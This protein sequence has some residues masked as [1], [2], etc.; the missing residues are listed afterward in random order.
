MV[1]IIAFIDPLHTI[2]D[3]HKQPAVRPRRRRRKGFFIFLLV[4]IALAGAVAYPP[5]FLFLVRQALTAEAWRY[6]FQL[7]IGQMEGSVRGPLWLYN[8]QL[9]HTSEAGTSTVLV[10]NKARTSFAWKH[11]IWQKDV[12][13]W[14]DLALDG[15]NGD[16]DLP[17]DSRQGKP[18]TTLFDLL[19]SHKPP[20]LPLPTFLRISHANIAIRQQGGMV[21]LADLNLDASNVEAGH[22]VIGA[23]SVQEPWITSVFSNCRGSLAIQNSRLVLSGMRLTDAFSITS[24]S[25]DLPELLRGQ[26][27]MEF[28]LDAFS[29]NIQG[30]LSS[31]AHEEHLIFESSGTFSNISVAQLASFFGHDA[32]GAIEQGKFTFHGSPRDLAKSTFTT[33][34]NAGNFRWGA[35]RWNSLV[36]GVTYVD[37]RLLVPDFALRQAHNSLTLKGDMDVPDDWK[38][39]WTTDFSF[40]V[41]AK[42]DNLSELSALLGPGFGD[43]FGKLTVDGSV[44]GENSSFNGQIIVSGSHLSFRKAPLDQLQAAIKL[45]GNE[46]QVTNAEFIHGDDYLRADG[47]VNILGRKRYWGEVKASIADLALY[48]SFLQPPIAPEAFGGGLVLDW[49]G[50]GDQSAHSGAFMV[51]LNHLHPLVSG[52]G[53]AGWQPIDLNAEGTYSPESIFFSNFVLGNGDATLAS[54][55][56]ANPRSLSLQDMKLMHGS[57]VWL[58]GSAQIPL[59]VWAAWQNPSSA[60]WWNFDSPC[61]LALKMDGLSVGD[62]ISLS[63]R[64]EPFDGKIT[65]TLN[66]MGSLSKLTASGQLKIENASAATPGGTLGNGVAT[67]TFQGDKMTISS[68]QGSW[69][70]SPAS[71][72]SG[73]IT[74]GDVRAPDFDVDLSFPSAPVTLGEGLT[75]EAGLNLHASGPP[76]SLTLSGSAQLTSIWWKQRASIA[77]LLA[78]GSTG[79]VGPLP[80][81]RIPGPPTWRLD[82]DARGPAY[83][84]LI[85]G[86]GMMTPS[87]H[88]TGSLSSPVVTGKLDV[89]GFSLQEGPD[90][91]SIVDGTYFLN[92][93]NPLATALVLHAKGSAGAMG[94][95]GYI[96]GTLSGKLFSW[97]PEVTEAFGAAAAGPPS[98]IEPVHFSLDVD[99]P[100]RPASVTLPPGPAQP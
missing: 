3:P 95:D 2:A 68:A 49:S 54:R 56:V 63:G 12:T 28:A 35:R 94:Y 58:T 59:N 4:V 72:A 74:A 60:T 71:F 36:A 93:T 13:T 87:L 52:T 64:R 7:S 85:S 19:R 18:R 47:V 62:A 34:F 25:A 32:D 45:D 26:L 6:G 8:S 11:L 55:V 46:V 61:K 91:M 99:V 90:T 10:I 43:F 20:R 75:A 9:V 80:A 27:Q 53:G 30:E 79:L 88:V 22:L 5:T 15:V 81:L 14:R 76:A 83:A 82:L 33:Y 29:G 67:L 98:G 50:D 57:A 38:H 96:L 44:R 41:A 66:T 77:S 31:G 89:A 97:G 17:T 73:S 40:Q 78:S 86:S 100:P 84:H 51:R 23:I 1:C 42:I 92:P 24:A 21:R 70:S 16:I 69:N 39:W 65:G 37:H 48:D